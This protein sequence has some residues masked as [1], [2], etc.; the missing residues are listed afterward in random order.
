[1]SAHTAE[2]GNV[3]YIFLRYADCS[4]YG[5]GGNLFEW[6][7]P[8]LPQRESS[9]M[10]LQIAQLS[11]HYDGTGVEGNPQPQYLVYNNLFSDNVYSTDNST[12]LAT[13]LTRDDATGHY[14]IPTD[15]PVIQVS[16]NLRKVSF[17][18]KNPITTD[19]QDIGD[20]GSIMILLK[21][22]RPQHNVV[23]DN[24]IM[25]YVPSEVG[26]PRYNKL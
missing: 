2:L 4:T 20:T 25:S 24:T 17:S 10:Y 22:I 9:I 6:T 11:L 14:E 12:V 1:M 21:V 13:I 23:R 3:E 8:I 18:L 15:A 7:L 19:N 26:M 5:T 16:S